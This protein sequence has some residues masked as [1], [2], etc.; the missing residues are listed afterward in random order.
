ML[1]ESSS[2][3]SH[4]FSNVSDVRQCSS[5][6]VTCE[7]GAAMA[8]SLA[9]GGLCPL[10]GDQVLSPAATRSM[11]SMMQV[12]G[13]KDYSTTFHYKVQSLPALPPLFLLQ[14]RACSPSLCLPARGNVSSVFRFCFSSVCDA[15]VHTSRVQQPRLPAGCGSRR[16]GAACVFS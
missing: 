6:E 7:S 5:T 14:H 8:A 12:A 15:D 9:N 11:L 10:S 1:S 16:F 3:F 13:M 4:M 2:R